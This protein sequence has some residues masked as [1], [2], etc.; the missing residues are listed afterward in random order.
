M[1]N[2]VNC[3]IV[4]PVSLG[5]KPRRYCGKRCANQWLHATNATNPEYAKLPNICYAC[6]SMTSRFSSGKPKKYCCSGC[7]V[8]HRDKQRKEK[9]RIRNQWIEK[10]CT[11]KEE[12]AKLLGCH[13][14]TITNRMN[15]L[16]LKTHF[17]GGQVA[18]APR[19]WAYV[20]TV[21]IEHIRALY[22][23]G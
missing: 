2:C 13:P 14:S 22:E 12:V 19:R 23:D 18:A 21:H 7:R 4:N 6:G 8:N 16:G 11:A 17:K 10:N 1:S 5:K 3:G 20:E 15:V 9:S